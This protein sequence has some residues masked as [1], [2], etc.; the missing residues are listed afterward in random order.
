MLY[1]KA[2]IIFSLIKEKFDIETGRGRG[3]G[4]YLEAA[5]RGRFNSRSYSRVNG[6]DGGDRDYNRPRGNG[7]YRPAARQDRGLLSNQVSRS[8]P[9]QSE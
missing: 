8:G 2:Q 1:I 6:Q 4:G 7:F 3:R 5:P 9:K